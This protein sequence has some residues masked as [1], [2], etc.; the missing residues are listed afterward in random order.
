MNFAYLFP[1]EFKINFQKNAFRVR[2]IC[3]YYHVK[4]L[5]VTVKVRKLEKEE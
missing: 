1:E 5:K 2:G 3:L 4:M